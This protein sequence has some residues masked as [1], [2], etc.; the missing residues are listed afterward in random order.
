MAGQYSVIL[1]DHVT[2]IMHRRSLESLYRGTNYSSKFPSP[3]RHRID[4]ILARARN[5][6]SN[7]APNSIIFQPD[8]FVTFF[9]PTTTTDE[10]SVNVYTPPS[11][12]SRFSGGLAFRLIHSLYMPAELPFRE[13]NDG[14]QHNRLV[15]CSIHLYNPRP[16]KCHHRYQ[17]Y[18][19]RIRFGK[20]IYSREYIDTTRTTEDHRIRDRERAVSKYIPGDELCAFSG[21]R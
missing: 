12:I 5:H 21:A 19:S 7:C 2:T 6:L 9:R 16:V 20:T 14:K 18:Y 15:R 10:Y 13:S 17:V 3:P 4:T 11:T 8:H 1:R